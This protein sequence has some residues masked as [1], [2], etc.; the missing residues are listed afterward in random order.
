MP[1]AIRSPERQSLQCSRRLRCIAS[2]LT[3]GAGRA[4]AVALLLA[5]PIA[6]CGPTR[7]ADLGTANR[8]YE[9]GDFDRALA[10]ARAA[11]ARSKGE[12]RDRAR[13]LEGLALLRLGRP[14][15]ATEPLRD[16]SDAADRALAADACVS[17]GTAQVRC[18]E[19]AEAAQAYRRAALLSDGAESW[20]AHSI[21]ARCFE[22]AGLTRAAEES[23]L[24]A[25]ETA[26]Q[27]AQPPARAESPVSP[28][29]RAD[30]TKSPDSEAT[31][32]STERTINGMAIEPIRYAIQAGAFS[33]RARAVQMAESLDAQLVGKS[34][35]RARVVEKERPG[36]SSVFVVQVGEFANRVLAGRA[37]A[38]LPKSVYTVERYAE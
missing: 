32:T 7:T 18:E 2:C 30:A 8:S 10:E 23:R 31:R 26:A 4:I 19:F 28:A 24:A 36:D 38:Q 21:A 9:A 27:R 37:I 34:L 6:A 35:G 33:D 12:D 5:A 29:G 22:R 13:Y 1:V 14:R 20:R 15:E 16:A 25:G 17:L 11:A 3:G